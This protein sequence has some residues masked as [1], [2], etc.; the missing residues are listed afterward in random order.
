MADEEIKKDNTQETIDS[1]AGQSD[2][3]TDYEKAEEKKKKLTYIIVFVV[4]IILAFVLIKFVIFPWYNNDN[5]EEAVEE[6]QEEESKEPKDLGHIYTISNLT[7]NP[8][9]SR[10]RR[11]AVFEIAVSV[12]SAE[13][14]DEMKKYESVI[15]DN[16]IQYFRSKTVEDLS[17]D[18]AIV[19]IKE[20]LLKITG[21]IVGSEELNDIYFTRYILQ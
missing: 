18:T 3:M 21:D 17:V 15:K 4:Q 8:S 6:V 5:A 1:E 11:F 10:G 19:G 14:V 2:E 16:Y 20:D 12:K 13:F 9:G 7:V